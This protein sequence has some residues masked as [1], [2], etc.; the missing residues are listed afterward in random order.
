MRPHPRLLPLSLCIAAALPLQAAEKYQLDWGRCPAKDPVPIFTDT[1]P[2]GDEKV[3]PRKKLNTTLEGDEQTGTIDMPVFDGN[4]ALNRG[5]QFLG[6]DHVTYDRDKDTYVAEGHVRYQDPKMRIL[7]AKAQGNQ[8]NDSHTIDDIRYQIVSHRG[9]GTADRID[10]TGSKGELYDATYTTCPPEKRDWE[11][12][13]SRIDVDTEEG[14]AVAHNAKIRIGKVPVAYIPW[15]KF[16]IDDRRR[17]GL[18]FPSISQ[19]QRNGFDWRQPIYIN[20]APNYD[21]TISPRIMTERGVAI[22]NEFRY[23]NGSGSG[24]ARASWM[25]ND[26]LRNDD[27]RGSFTYQAFQNLS[28]N[29]QARANL[30]WLSDPRYL[31]DFN[32]SSV[33]LAQYSAMSEIGVYG[34]G[35]HWDASISA[36]HWVRTDYTLTE[37]S[38]PYD[39]LPRLTYNLDTPVGVLFRAGVNAEAVRFQHENYR[40]F[41][42]GTFDQTGPS[43]RIPGG[44]RFDIKPF[45]S[46]PL[47]GNWWFLTPT[48]AWRYTAYQL[49]G[50]LANNNAKD[51]AIAAEALQGRY[52][53]RDSVPDTL[54]QPLV[55]RNPTRS[56]P[57]V[58]LDGG[59]QFDRNVQWGG[60]DYVQTLEPRVFYLHAPYRDQSALPV[61]DTGLLTYSWGQLFRDNRYSSA[62]RQS[63]ANQVTFAV[64]TRMNRESDGHEK[65][66]ASLGQIR[67]LS[68]TR[69]TLPGEI[70]LTRG[71]SAWVADANYAF[72]DRWTM[73][74][75]YQWDPRTK[76]RDLVSVR[77]RYLWG[78]DGIVNL[79]YRYRR[80]LLEQSDLQFLYPITSSWSIVGRYYVSLRDQATWKHTVKPLEIVG[81]VQWD[82]CCV[83]IRIVGR[84]YVATREGDLRNGIMLEFELKGLGSAGQD[85]RRILRRAILGYFRDDLYLVP[86]EALSSGQHTV[87]PDPI[88]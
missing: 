56:L 25:P 30:L 71:R 24:V 36:D 81:G 72:N 19:T 7:A 11:L 87:D 50:D 8:A 51:R 62:D 61:F 48:V 86:P 39:R 18:L 1:K 9:N 28:P 70:P 2:T 80:G 83:A 60:K 15:F 82:S 34:R 75:S 67:Y 63:D 69:V 22:D 41:A 33:G 54:W 23:L 6:A 35:H 3:T 17:T 47:Q 53:N 29:W 16:P 43:L 44:S 10:L 49:D 73:G 85:T 88:Q 68:D 31:E 46:M 42:A 5:N 64:T 27:T 52:W 65:L 37:A 32:N 4:V 78:E 74:A 26:K 55:K 76:Q 57:I 13:A 40:N 66:S 21:D 38:L 12:K 84:R 59:I 77:T 45:V 14:M 79:S 20:I 58:S